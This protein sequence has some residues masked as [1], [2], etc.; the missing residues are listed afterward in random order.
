MYVLVRDGQIV[1]YPYS[2]AALRQEHPDVSFPSI[3]GASLLQSYGVYPVLPTDRPVVDHT[4]TLAESLPAQ[5]DSGEWQQVW[6]VVDAPEAEVLLRVAECAAGVR[7]KR[8]S[9]LA[10]SDRTQLDDSPLSNVQ[11]AAWATYRQALRDV[12]AQSGFPWTIDWPVQP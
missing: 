5:V 4:K 3:V 1:S 8:N 11:K 12:T 9:L 6:D 10:S 2:V 7:M